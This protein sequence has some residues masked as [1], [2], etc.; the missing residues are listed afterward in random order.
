MKIDGAIFDLD[1]TL[2]DSMPMWEN[3]PN[4]YLL[5]RGI[6]PEKDLSDK[7]K[8]MSIMQGVEHYRNNYGIL[9]DYQTIVNDINNMIYNFYASE[10][11]LKKGVIT[12]LEKLK[13]DKVKMCIATASQRNMVELVLK[14]HNI[15]HYFEQI[16]TCSEVGYGK[17]NPK[18]FNDALE[19]LGTKKQNTLVFEDA[20]HAIITAKKQG[21]MV[22]GIYDECSKNDKK[23][24]Q[25]Y[26]D[27]YIN[28]FEEYFKTQY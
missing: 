23:I 26:A 21:F 7:F 6:T 5:Q 8:S 22:V 1:G 14:R 11:Q 4:Q 27:Y 20:L 28:S 25:E 10:I 18:I 17:D 19:Y 2:I 12:F 13:K 15:L 16:F 9:D 3:I 24:I